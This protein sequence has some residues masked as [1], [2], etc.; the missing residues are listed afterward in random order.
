LSRRR[1]RALATAGLALVVLGN[2]ACWEQ[3]SPTWF[4]QM[5]R[6]PAVQ[7]FENTGVPGHP[8]DFSPP[9]GTLPTNGLDAPPTTV[10]DDAVTPA[11][12][13]PDDVANALVNPVPVSLGSL[14]NGKK[15]YET[16]CGPCHGA[17]GM[18]D[19]AVA[20]VFLG[21]LPLVVSQ[22]RSDGHIF[23]TI[24]HGRRRM[25]AYGRLT[26]QDRWDIVNYVRYLFPVGEQKLAASDPNGGLP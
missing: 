7:A 5:K 17:K 14:E 6:Q 16:Y 21:V 25:P 12:E 24:Q 2:T 3:W 9:Q 23:V 13:I 15:Q 1:T 4:P 19:G 22:A 11:T 20:K 18:A 8:Q 10:V 26:V